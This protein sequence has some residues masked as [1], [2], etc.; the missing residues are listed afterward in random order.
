M[1]QNWWILKT[2]RSEILFIWNERRQ[3]Y[4]YKTQIRRFLE[5]GYDRIDRKQAYGIFLKHC[6]TG[7]KLDHGNGVKFYTFKKITES[8]T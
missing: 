2:T 4:R 5:Q 3:I 8:Y 1:V 6:E 7:L